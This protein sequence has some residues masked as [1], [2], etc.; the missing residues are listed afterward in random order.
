MPSAAE[1]GDMLLER[2]GQLTYQFLDAAT[3]VWKDDDDLQSLKKAFDVANESSTSAKL[4]TQALQKKFVK[5]FQPLFARIEAKDESVLDEPV[6]FLQRVQARAKFDGASAEVRATCWEYARQIVQS[7]T[8]GHVYEKCPSRMVQRVASMADKIVK[9]MQSGS[10]D[11]SKLNPME[12]SQ[13]MLKGIDPSALEEW[14]NSLKSSGNMEQIMSMMTSMLGE[15]DSPLGSMM[16]GGLGAMLN[17]PA[18]AMLN[19]P[20][21]AEMMGAGGLGAML[22]PALAGMMGGG[23]GSITMD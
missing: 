11:P 8:M 13:E 4:F 16:G 21:M 7:A 3:E 22:N 14:G 23:F 2:F 10:F 9:E 15:K 17:N 18:M 1:A 19:N 12:L 20:A 6:V 5:D